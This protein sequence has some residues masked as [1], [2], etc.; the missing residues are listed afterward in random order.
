M[1]CRVHE[2]IKTV[3]WVAGINIRILRQQCGSND[4]III[5]DGSNNSA[6]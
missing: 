1:A 2:K 3:L 4:Y 5:L 6:I